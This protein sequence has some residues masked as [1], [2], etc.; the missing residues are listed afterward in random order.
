[1]PDGKFEA[2]VVAVAHGEFREVKVKSE[3]VYSM[4]GGD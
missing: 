2:A 1:M 3:V 4:K